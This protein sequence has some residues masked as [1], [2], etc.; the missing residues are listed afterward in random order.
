MALQRYTFTRSGKVQ[1]ELDLQ[2]GLVYA[3][4]PRVVEASITN[5]DAHGDVAGTIHA[6]NWVDRQVA[7]AV[8]FDHPVVERQ[9]LPFREGEKA[10]RQLL[11][12]DLG[13]SR[14]LEVRVALSTVDITGARANLA[15]ANSKGFDAIREAARE[16]WNALLGRVKID[17]PTR[18]KRIFYTALY[19]AFLHPS[20]IADVDGRV[21]GPDGEI[22]QARG[23]VYYSTLSLWDTFR[24]NFPLLALL[25]PE[26]VDGIVQTLLQHHATYGSLPVWTAWGREIWCMIGNPALSIIATAVADDFNGFDRREALDAMIKTATQ[27]R[28]HAPDW[29]QIDTK[30][31]DRY[32]YLPFD[33]KPNESVSTTVEKG[34]GDDAVARVAKAVGD[35]A[36]ET[37]FAQRARNY[38]HLFDPQ[39]RF[40][41]GRDSTGNWRPDFDPVT[42][43]SP[44]SN[45]GDYTEGNAWQYSLAPALHDPQGLVALIGGEAMFGHWLD[46]F[47]SLNTLKTNPFL[48][49]EAIIGQ[50]AHGNEPSHH[51]AWLYA[52]TPTPGHGHARLRE[53]HRRFYSDKP[54]GI[55]GNNDAGQMSAWYVLATLGFYP[56]VPASGEFVIGA[57]EVR[58]ARLLLA[59]GK[60]LQIRAPHFD[61][62][63]PWA[64]VVRWNGAVLQA[65]SINY[66]NLTAGGELAFEMHPMP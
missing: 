11:T 36:T 4:T 33:L 44:M 61:E 57:P 59:N 26:R 22:L 14:V 56:V 18:Q 29:A 35:R 19:H 28:Q 23:G 7:F 10:V 64:R 39:T 37:F 53:I 30:M 54:D 27:P 58:S 41:R 5:D 12:F 47:F 6:L 13:R 2:H 8:H 63:H 46:Q 43:T 52:Y 31:L 45:P 3:D 1:V 40:M 15:T 62:S 49:Q 17:A 32:G 50:Y 65:K 16:A 60:K 42:P 51:I 66:G 25:V 20:N 24:A 9:V 21:R 48:G 55:I 38:A 34:I